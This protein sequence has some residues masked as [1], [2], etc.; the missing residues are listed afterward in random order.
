MRPYESRLS[1]TQWSCRRGPSVEII[2]KNC[3]CRWLEEVSIDA[4][5]SVSIEKSPVPGQVSRQF[6]HRK[7]YKASSYYYCM[8]ARFVC[9]V[10]EGAEDFEPARV[11]YTG[12]GKKYLCDTLRTHGEFRQGKGQHVHLTEGR[13]TAMSYASQRARFY[14]DVPILLVVDTEKVTEEICYDG[15][16]KARALNVGSFLPYDIRIDQEGKFGWDDWL[17][18]GRIETILVESSENDIHEKIT[19]YLSAV[20]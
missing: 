2:Y 10:T 12:T 19:R 13:V 16:Y 17:G 1:I 9:E 8:V 15:E 11:L 3:E 6:G 7:L 18:V 4:N 14:N 5:M 20:C